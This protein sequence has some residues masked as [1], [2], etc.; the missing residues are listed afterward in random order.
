MYIN[1]NNGSYLLLFY[2]QPTFAY[3]CSSLP[4]SLPQIFDGRRQNGRNQSQR[5]HW[6]TCAIHVHTGL[7]VLCSVKSNNEEYYSIGNEKK[8]DRGSYSTGIYIKIDNIQTYIYPIQIRYDFDKVYLINR[9]NP[10][11]QIILLY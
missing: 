6:C 7:P 1:L 10:L 5:W 3:L 8:R 4:F 11:S 2:C 9:H